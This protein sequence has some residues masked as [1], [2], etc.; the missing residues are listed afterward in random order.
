MCCIILPPVVSFTSSLF[1]V[2]SLQCS[3]SVGGSCFGVCC[4]GSR[5]RM[6]VHRGGSVMG[7][8]TLNGY[9]LLLSGGPQSQG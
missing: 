6:A 7:L 5:L 9:G 3:A 8:Y 2:T 1:V 4:E